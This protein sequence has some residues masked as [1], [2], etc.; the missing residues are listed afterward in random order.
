MDDPIASGRYRVRA[1]VEREQSVPLQVQAARF[2]TRDDAD[3]FAHLA[4]ND[5]FQSMVVEK[6]APGGC[7]LQLSLVAGAI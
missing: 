5:H 1:V 2:N 6:L 7:W 4:A 3:T